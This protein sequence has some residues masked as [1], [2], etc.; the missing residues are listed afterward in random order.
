MEVK[1]IKQLKDL[2]KNINDDFK[3]EVSIMEEISEQ[4]LLN[5]RYPFPWRHKQAKIE[6]HDIGY[7]DKEV[8]FGVYESK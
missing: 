5:S 7:S 1:T 6:F 8:C 4:E 2:I 3:I